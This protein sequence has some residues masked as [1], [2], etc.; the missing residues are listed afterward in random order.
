MI[1]SIDTT[2][3]IC[4][5]NSE[6]IYSGIYLI[7]NWN[8]TDNNDNDSWLS[9]I[10]LVIKDA[11]DKVMYSSGLDISTR[12]IN[13]YTDSWKYNWEIIAEDKAGNKT[14]V[15][16]NSNYHKT[17]DM[18]ITYP[19]TLIDDTYYTN[20]PNITIKMVANMWLWFE[21]I[22]DTK[23]ILQRQMCRNWNIK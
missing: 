9:G 14:V 13:Y 12:E 5:T 6:S 18:T 15:K 10:M 17:L 11:T 21:V 2:K 3:P 23:N 8:C 16:S 4:S 1:F 20:N 19:G 22:G 7:L